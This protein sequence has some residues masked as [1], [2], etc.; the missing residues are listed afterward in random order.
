MAASSSKPEDCIRNKLN[1]TK[2]PGSAAP[3]RTAHLICTFKGF[4][5]Q[6]GSVLHVNL[7]KITR[8]ATTAEQLVLELTHSWANAA[9]AVHRAQSTGLHLRVEKSLGQGGQCMVGRWALTL[10]AH[11][12]G[13]QLTACDNVSY[14]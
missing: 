8:T 11:H 10:H 3:S 9:A 4:T 2:E 7:I 12:I 14:S 6:P 13:C 5:I 1:P